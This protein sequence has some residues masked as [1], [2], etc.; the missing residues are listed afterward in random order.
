MKIFYASLTAG[1]L[2]VYSLS[3][4]QVGQFDVRFNLNSVDC[5]NN[6]IFVDIEVK[7]ANAGSTFNMSDQNYR[8]SFNRDAIAP[9]NPPITQPPNPTDRSFFI[10]DE[11]CPSGFVQLNSL[12][13]FYNSHTLTGSL[14]TIVSVNVVL[15][16]GDGYPVGELDNNPKPP[17]CLDALDGPDWPNGWVHVTRLRVQ[18]LGADSCV[19]FDWHDQ[20]PEEFPPTFIGEKFLGSLFEVAEG[21]Y[22]NFNF[23]LSDSC[24]LDLPIELLS[25]EGLDRDCE[26]DLKW[27]TA[28]EINNDYFIIMGSSDGDNFQ[29]IGRVQ[30]SGTTSNV[31]S[32]AFTVENVS[33]LNYF[34]LIQVDYDGSTQEYETITI[35]SSCY[36]ENI[37]NGITELFPNPVG[38]DETISMKFY[39]NRLDT[40]ALIIISDVLGRQVDQAVIN[41]V[42]GPNTL[43]YDPVR[44]APGT[45]FVQVQG[46]D[47]YSTPQK[48]VKVNP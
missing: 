48:F 25:F 20:T 17:T 37:L 11:L 40:D 8:F 15:A 34:K 10:Q 5:P 12:T 42:Q 43:E 27:E 16:G 23:C 26:I 19:E 36:D 9:I 31:S 33:I 3:I 46:N 18:L 24:G 22:N 2:L 35:R 39:T 41:L 45:Y 14:D 1:L 32:Y 4:A 21:T 47:W 44:L 28:T 30:G 29:E 6:M 13:S 38:Q 7:A